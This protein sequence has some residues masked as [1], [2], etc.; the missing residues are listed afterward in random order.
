MNYSAARHP[1]S[2]FD[3]FWHIFDELIATGY[4]QRR[5]WS[6]TANHPQ[7]RNDSQIGPQMTPNRKYSRC[8]PPMIPR[9]NKEW[10]GFVSWLEILL[11]NIN[12]TL[13]TASA[14]GIWID[15]SGFCRQ[16]QLYC[17]D[18][19][20]YSHKNPYSSLRRIRLY[21]CN[22]Y[23]SPPIFLSGTGVRFTETYAFAKK[24]SQLRSLLKF[25]DFERN[26][27]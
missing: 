3:I 17:P 23:R 5:K 24:T 10:H 1:D 16:E 21:K 15:Q 8:I 7:T 9:V 22:L 27:P 20:K 26:K 11:L 19:K 12:R 2:F 14:P 6:P 25:W 13:H 18:R 4:V